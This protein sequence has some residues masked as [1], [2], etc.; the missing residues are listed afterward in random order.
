[1]T[2]VFQSIKEPHLIDVTEVCEHH[3]VSVDA[4]LS[5]HAVIERQAQHGLNELPKADVV[6]AWKK[7]FA[8]FNDTLILILIGRLL[9]FQD[10]RPLTIDHRQEYYRRLQQ[11]QCHQ[12]QFRAWEPSA[13]HHEQL[14][15]VAQVT[16]VLSAGASLTPSPVMATTW[17]RR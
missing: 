16:H 11:E 6:P 7:F 5:H 8:Q 13:L 2:A 15:E 17:P 14:E 9:Q 10:L 4:G 1:M 3:E 12:A